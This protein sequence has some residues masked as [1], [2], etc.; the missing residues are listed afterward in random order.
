MAGLV[1][2]RAM[3]L[4]TARPA[5]LADTTVAWLERNSVPWDLLVM[6][7]DDDHRSSPEVKA[8]AY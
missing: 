6:R 7:A 4:V 8:E 2:E 3:V 5:R 1:G